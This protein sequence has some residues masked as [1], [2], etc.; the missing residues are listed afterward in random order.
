MEAGR[1]PSEQL[2]ARRD[3]RVE[4][5][6]PVLVQRGK[7]GIPLLTS[8]VSFR[9]LFV[10]TNMA[11]AIRSL[12][13]LRITLGARIIDTHAM[14]VHVKADGEDRVVGMGLQFWGLAGAD[15]FAWDSYVNT[16][17]TDKRASDKRASESH[18]AAS[19]PSTPSGVRVMLKVE[20]TKS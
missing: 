6:L 15:R 16:L 17:L 5:V 14:V 4:G 18:P 19:E 11:S 9:G 20:P 10:P 3:V 13:R 1:L 12:V 8:D 7:A 2:N